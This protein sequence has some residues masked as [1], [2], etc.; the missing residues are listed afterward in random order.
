MSALLDLTGQKY[1]LLT[2]LGRAGRDTTGKTTWRCHCEC[3]SESTVVGLNLKT[4]TTK[5]CGCLKHRKGEANPKYR[6]ISLDVARERKRAGAQFRNWRAAVMQRC[7]V[8]I[9]CGA[10]AKLHAHHLNGSNEFPESRFDTLN[11]V[12]LCADCH[13]KFHVTFGR[14][15]GFTEMDAETFVG[16]PIA[17]LVTRHRAKN[18]LEDLRKARHY[19]D[20]LIAL[21]SGEKV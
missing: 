21:E 7:P 11:A 6:P 20:L 16:S 9:R 19:L 5:S 4:R 14:K 17:W 12:T 15:K 1:G 10:E 18:G 13:V 3:G 2:V 8:C